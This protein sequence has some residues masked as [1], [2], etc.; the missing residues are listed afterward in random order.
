LTELAALT[1]AELEMLM[2]VP[3]SRARAVAELARRDAQAKPAPPWPQV[4]T[5]SEVMDHID[6]LATVAPQV[7]RFCSSEERQ[8]LDAHLDMFMRQAY[9]HFATEAAIKAR[10]RAQAAR[11]S[12]AADASAD[13]TD[14]SALLDFYVRTASEE[15]MV[16]G[17]RHQRGLAGIVHARITEQTGDDGISLDDF[18]SR[19]EV[20]DWLSA[21]P[22]LV[23]SLLRIVSGETYA[24]KPWFA[25]VIAF[26]RGRLGDERVVEQLRAIAERG[27][28]P[29]WVPDDLKEAVFAHG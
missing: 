20:L 5:L 29:L 15:D 16:L 11:W 22:V 27:D 6:R 25:I 17:E 14:T 2:M 23:V 21:R 3:A 4:P 12:L 26:E 1:T 19:L 10:S 18:T 8:V 7:T 13:W 9:R 28:T 24:G